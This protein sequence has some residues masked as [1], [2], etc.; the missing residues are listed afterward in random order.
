MAT[1]AER[2]EARAK[3]FADSVASLKNIRAVYGNQTVKAKVSQAINAGKLT[4][5]GAS[6]LLKAVETHDDC[7]EG[8]L[9]LVLKGTNVVDGG[10]YCDPEEA[11]AAWEAHITPADDTAV[12]KWVS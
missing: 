5:R 9:F 6:I 3:W 2:Q 1:V 8:G 10:H 12:L 4:Q 11:H 7:A